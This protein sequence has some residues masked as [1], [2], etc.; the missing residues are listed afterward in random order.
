VS[1]SVLCITRDPGPRVAGVLAPFRAVADEIVVAADERVAP[2]DLRW[3]AG[4]ADLVCTFP[5]RGGEEHLPWAHALC[6]GEWIFRIDG[7]EVAPP[8]LLEELAGAVRRPIEEAWVPRRWLHGDP[9]TW[10]D[11]G[12][13]WPD[14]QNRLV[15]NSASLR[16]EGVLHRGAVP[17]LPA[18]YLRAA[19][20]HLDLMV[21]DRAARAAKARRYQLARPGT[22]TLAAAEL[23]HVYYLPERRLALRTAA[24]PPEDLAHLEAA[25]APA[26]GEPGA[27]RAQRRAA[28]LDEILELAPARELAESAYA[29]QLEVVDPPGALTAGTPFA[30]HLRVTNRGDAVWAW[31]DG[32]G[33]PIRVGHAWRAPDGHPAEDAGGRSLL[34]RSLGPGESTVVPVLAV[35]PRAPGRYEL[36]LDLVHELVRWFGQPATVLVEV[37]APAPG[38]SFAVGEQSLEPAAVARVDHAPAPAGG[39]LRRRR[40]AA[41]APLLYLGWLGYG[42]LGDEAMYDVVRERFG[43]AVRAPLHPQLLAGDVDFDGVRAVVLGG[44]TLI[45]HAE[46]RGV[47]EA[48]LA[49][50]PG[51]PAFVLGAGVDDPLFRRDAGIEDRGDLPAWAGLLPRLSRVAVRG[52]RSRA[53]LAELGVDA[54][55]CG[56][57]ALLLRGDT[58]AEPQDRV[59]G[60]NLGVAWR[61]W[62]NEPGLLLDQVVA[63]GRRAA[64]EGWRLRLLPIWSHDVPYLAAAAQAIGEAADLRGVPATAAAFLDEVAPCRVFVGQKLHAT[65]LAQVAGVP[66]VMLEYHPKCRE[67][68]ASLGLER[69]VV[70]ADELV[71]YELLA[72]VREV[73]RERDALRDRLGSAI[74]ARRQAIEAELEQVEAAIG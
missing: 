73:D 49:A 13:W 10:I 47:L 62:G 42:N 59:L 48:F 57:L 25:L 58:A 63:F 21:N 45:G 56:D 55:V 30:V 26:G 51:G 12:P 37:R 23:S 24:V 72:L 40:A 36:E 54:E 6:T 14:Y 28:S 68:Q 67:V 34:P 5:H 2:E 16:F 3:Y 18:D 33:P 70:R 64:A 43:S 35:A 9:P 60:L 29:A 38:W 20:Y 41:P 61:I 17:R 8:A 53:I 4:V 1:L 69:L 31:G 11:E 66:S 74:A 50:R 15:R 46:F 44:G 7:D 27:A 39:V 19:L 52:E 22:A 65:V 32:H 71:V